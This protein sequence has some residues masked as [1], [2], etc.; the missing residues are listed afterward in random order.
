VLIWQE[1]H[2]LREEFRLRFRNI[3]R[4]M[5]CVTCEKCR[6]WGKLQILGLGTAIKILLTPEAELAARVGYLNRQEVIA[7]LN[8]LHQLSKS[9]GFAA[10]AGEM[11][12]R[13]KLGMYGHQ[14]LVAVA[15]VLGAA[16]V[17]ALAV[18]ARRARAAAASAAQAATAAAAAATSR[19][20]L[21]AAWGGEL[22][23]VRSL[24]QDVNDGV[25]GAAGSVDVCD[26]RGSTP[27]HAATLNG[28]MP[29]VQCLVE[30][31]GADVNRARDDGYTAVTVAAAQGLTPVLTYLLEHGGEANHR[32]CQGSTPLHVAAERNRLSAVLCLLAHGA[33]LES[34][35]RDGRTP[36]YLAARNAHLAV[37]TALLDAG[38]VVDAPKVRPS[39][40]HSLC[41]GI[42]TEHTPLC[43]QPFG[44]P[45]RRR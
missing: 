15:A 33:G 7:L 23:T 29:V 4:I 41:P 28:H 32:S 9:V 27:L 20:L 6:V 44:K 30:D 35:D 22:T 13:H 24:V 37:V 8:T 39:P 45:T 36:L 40:V 42:C 16:L 43:V 26:E 10:H 1:K 17:V 14:S 18:R 19:A 34:A 31:G 25:P 12:L 5:D 3:S 38:A 11:E 2:T 21:S